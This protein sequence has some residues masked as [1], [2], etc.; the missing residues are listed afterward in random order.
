MTMERGRST[1]GLR[2]RSIMLHLGTMP[3]AAGPARTDWCLEH[4]LASLKIARRSYGLALR[5]VLA[6]LPHG[7]GLPPAY[8]LHEL[9][10]EKAATVIGR[11]R[12]E[13]W[14]GVRKRLDVLDEHMRQRNLMLYD[15]EWQ[16][17]DKASRTALQSA[18]DGFNW[19]DDARKD[20]D[21]GQLIDITSFTGQPSNPQTADTLVDQAHAMVHS[22]GELVGGLFGCRMTYDEDR[23]YDECVV[24]LLHL[25]FGTS[26]GLRVRYECTVCREDPGDCEHEPGQTYAVS[27]ARSEEGVCTVCD[28]AECPAHEQGVIYEIVADTKLADPYLREVTLTPRPRDPLCRITGRSVDDDYLRATLGRLPEPGEIVLDHTCMYPC[29]GFRD[30]PREPSEVSA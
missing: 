9:H 15:A 14:F 1:P 2:F 3:P 5:K 19:L 10:S 25:R 21:H 7:L 8:P 18:A 29:T 23:W 16:E 6:H 13:S 27:A 28:K 4:G 17:A 12:M 30:M 20:L 11:E 22:A 26:A 24:S